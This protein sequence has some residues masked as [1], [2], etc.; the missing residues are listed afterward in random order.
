MMVSDC[1]YVWLR[2]CFRTDSRYLC[3]VVRHVEEEILRL[4]V[5]RRMARSDVEGETGRS[6]RAKSS[7]GFKWKGKPEKSMS[8]R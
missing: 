4:R 1:M 5:L 7:A 3:V 6:A 2:Q 8:S